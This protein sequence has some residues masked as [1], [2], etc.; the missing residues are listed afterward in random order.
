MSKKFAR[1]GLAA[2]TAAL[3]G[4]LCTVTAFASSGSG[5]SSGSAGGMGTVGYLI[6]MVLLFAVMYFILIRPQKKK[7]KEAKAMQGALQI[8]DEIVIL[9]SQGDY[10]ITAD[11]MAD[12]IDTINYELICM[13]GARL[14]RIYV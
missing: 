13:F 8:G 11:M 9:G 14:P 3:T 4:A 1:L 6:F 5:S 12:E 10:E 7:D 2:G